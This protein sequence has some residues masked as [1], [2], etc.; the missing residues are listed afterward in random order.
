MLDTAH[1]SQSSLNHSWKQAENKCRMRNQVCCQSRFRIGP[2]DHGKEQENPSFYQIN[3]GK[4]RNQPWPTAFSRFMYR[5]GSSRHFKGRRRNS[6]HPPRLGV[7]Q[8]RRHSFSLSI[9][10][11]HTHL[12]IDILRVGRDS[13]CRIVF[14][15]C[16]GS[17]AEE[18][19]RRPYKFSRRKLMTWS[20]WTTP[21]MR[22]WGSTTGRA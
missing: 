13:P 19:R 6:I 5:L 17:V 11:S 8:L 10:L 1:L 2:R 15:R 20:A 12:R 21:A 9:S 14:L 18:T 3:N 7:F 4:E 16:A 22:P